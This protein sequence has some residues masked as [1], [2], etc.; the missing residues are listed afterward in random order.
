MI[1]ESI[2]LSDAFG[3]MDGVT[4]APSFVEFIEAGFDDNPDAATG[5]IL[6]VNL[7][8][9]TRFN[10]FDLSEKLPQVGD[11]TTVSLPNARSIKS[12]RS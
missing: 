1:K 4:S 6:A 2:T 11:N 10:A 9:K 3:S 7:P 8:A 12:F 5:N